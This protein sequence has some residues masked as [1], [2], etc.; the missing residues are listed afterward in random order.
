MNVLSRASNQ[1]VI[2]GSPVVL[3]Q[4]ARFKLSSSLSPGAEAPAYPM[5][6]NSTTSLWVTADSPVATHDIH[7]TYYSLPADTEVRAIFEP[8]AKR[9]ELLGFHTAKALWIRFQ[10]SATLATTDASK[11]ATVDMYANGPDPDPDAA[12][13]TV[14]NMP[15]NGGNYVFEGDSS[16]Y[17]YAEYRNEDDKYYIKQ[18]ECP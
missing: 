11:G 18:M 12:G 13:I 9:W 2:D 5:F 7:S 4:I 15:V 17:G 16:D 3:K 8:E 6:W 10:L 1:P 14:Y